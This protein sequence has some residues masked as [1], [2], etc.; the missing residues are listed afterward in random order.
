M[1][2]LYDFKAKDIKG[3]EQSLD[4]YKGKVAL[5]VNVA[6]KCGLTPHYKGLQE[7]YEKYNSKGFEILAF[8]SN[9]F[10]GQEPDSEERIQNFC[11][12]NYNVCFDMFSKVKVKGAEKVDI[13]NFL[14]SPET[15][16]TGA[17]EVAWNFQKY[18]IN[19]NGEIVKTYHPQTEPKDISIDIEKELSIVG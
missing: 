9:D 5:V 13:Y 16:K 17:G 3:T 6:S 8:P 18:L 2:T 14:T 11:S 1:T 7:L 4:K 19:K 10:A 12:T 15:N